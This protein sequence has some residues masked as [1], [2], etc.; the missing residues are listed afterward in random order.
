MKIVS[1]TVKLLK[2]AVKCRKMGKKQ[3]EIEKM[4]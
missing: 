2:P 3:R 4:L 1:K